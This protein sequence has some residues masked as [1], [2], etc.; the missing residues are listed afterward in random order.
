MNATEFWWK[1][2]MERNHLDDEELA[3]EWILE[4][5]DRL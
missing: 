5:Q 2:L 1:C 3:L 4:K